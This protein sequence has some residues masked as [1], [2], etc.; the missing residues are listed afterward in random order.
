[1]V[2]LCRRGAVG[3]LASLCVVVSVATVADRFLTTEVQFIVPAAAETVAL[4]RELWEPGHPV[5]SLYGTPVGDPVGVVWPDPERLLRPVE[6]RNMVLMLVD[7]Q[8]GENPLQIKTVCFVATRL[9][10]VL[11][12]ISA[13]LSLA[14]WAAA[15]RGPRP[16]DRTRPPAAARG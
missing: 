2:R 16:P 10:A 8:K 13:L 4:E 3:A 7:K 5:A 11:G 14:W 15:R 6:D 9:A 12:I 1:M